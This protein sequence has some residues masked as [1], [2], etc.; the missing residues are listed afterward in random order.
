MPQRRMDVQSHSPPG[1]RRLSSLRAVS[2]TLSSRSSPSI[3]RRFA[4]TLA[5]S[6]RTHLRP[7]TV[8]LLDRLDLLRHSVAARQPPNTPLLRSLP[9]PIAPPSTALRGRPDVGQLLGQVG[10]Q[11]QQE[12]L[13][14]GCVERV[15][16]RGWAQRSFARLRDRAAD[17]ASPLLSNLFSALQTEPVISSTVHHR[18]S[19]LA[20]PRGS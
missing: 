19:P 10:G 15:R 13:V 4:R 11:R 14:V 6:G 16:A 9:G 17:C 18:Q 20:G 2:L 7:G 1:V 5:Y 12:V 8:V 3:L